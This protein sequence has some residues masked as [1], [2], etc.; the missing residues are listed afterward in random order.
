[1]G[2]LDRLRAANGDGSFAE[3]ARSNPRL[4]IAIAAG[5]ILLL[6]WI[7]WAIYVTSEKGASG[8]LGVLVAWPA[9]LAA[10]ALISLPV[11]GGYLLIKRLSE[12]SGS[13]AIADT[14]VPED[15]DEEAP[16]DSAEEEDE[17]S[18][19]DEDDSEDEDD[20]DDD[21]DDESDDDSESGAEAKAAKS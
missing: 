6:A 18:G 13:T 2:A 1:M 20:E 21:S 15:E 4:L 12:D 8:G 19:E 11:I 17:S 5:A 9:I 10:L 7:G 16:D 3:R 14:D